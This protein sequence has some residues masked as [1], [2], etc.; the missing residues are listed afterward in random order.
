MD[1][2]DWCNHV[3]KKIVELSVS[4]GALR[5]GLLTDNM[6]GEALF[7]QEATSR[8]IGSTLRTRLHTAIDELGRSKLVIKKRVG[9]M[10]KLE[11]TSLGRARSADILP[12]WRESFAVTLSPGAEQLLRLVN[13]L[14]PQVEENY[15]WLEGVSRERFQ[16]LGWGDKEKRILAIRELEHHGFIHSYPPL[17]S[18]L[19]L[20][21]TY[22]GLVWETRRA[23]ETTIEPEIAHV[24]FTDIVGYSKLSMDEQTR[25]RARL[26]EVVRGMETYRRAQANQKVISRSTGDGIALVFF[27]N[28]A[29]AVNCAIELSRALPNHPELKLRTGVHTGPV[30]RDEDINDQVDV[31]GGGINFAQRVMDAGDAGHILISKAVADNLEQMGGWSDYLHDMGE[32]MVKHGA[33]IHVF[34]LHGDDFGNPELPE[35]CAPA[36]SLAKEEDE[37]RPAPNINCEGEDDLFVE[38]VKHEIFRET[39]Y[40]GPGALRA[41]VLKF[42]N[43]PKPG[44]KVAN[45]GNVRAQI[46]FYDFDWP[47]RVDYRIDYACWLNEETPYVSFD[48]ADNAIHYLIIGVFQNRKDGSDGFEPE[49]TIYG[50][51]PD[52]N[53]P[54]SRYVIRY[55]ERYRVKVRL[56]VGEHGEFST[57]YTCELNVDPGD[58]SFSFQYVTEEEKQRRKESARLELIK[59]IKEGEAFV[60]VPLINVAWDNLYSSIHE[61]IAKVS[62]W[63]DLQ[64]GRSVSS[65]FTSVGELTPYPHKIHEG[66]RRFFDELYTRIEHLKEIARDEGAELPDT[67]VSKRVQEVADKRRKKI[68]E[69]LHGF[70]A[71]ATA[72]LD[73]KTHRPSTHEREL[74]IWD[75]ELFDYLSEYLNRADTT[76]L[77]DEN[78]EQYTL[79]EGTPAWCQG[80]L[81]RVHTRIVRLNHLIEEISSGRRGV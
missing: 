16:E 7:G 34:N 17:G 41:D 5:T 53:A 31:A 58:E 52:R 51:S 10:Y 56:I 37:R 64:F 46:K 79:P 20:T 1:F 9:Q 72:L 33:R 44:H 40:Y 11:V 78:L 36:P 80:F 54:L 32:V 35:K 14:S 4:P 63:L 19:D 71:R 57:E 28:P 59:L 27:G 55:P 49:Y 81:N 48:L 75:N 77:S 43:E 15:V 60:M 50:N 69:D 12:L 65:R 70:V 21:S 8:F 66:Y 68:L 39:D 74:H 6:L 3:L 73:Y 42:A 22:R 24:L 23:P 45:V 18:E 76:L 67:D 26:K 2:V 62:K 61:W 30:R 47:E 25:L 13:S 38:L 29:A